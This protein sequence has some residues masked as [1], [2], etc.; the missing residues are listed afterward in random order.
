M[1][2]SVPPRSSA[3]NDVVITGIGIVSSAGVGA[4]EN[5]DAFSR[6]KAPVFDSETFAPHTVHPAP[7]VDWNLQIPKRGDQRQMETWQR[8]GTYCAGLALEDAGIR[9]NEA[10]TTSMDMIVAAAGGERDISVDEMIL[11]A[12]QDRTDFGVLINEKLTTELRPTLFLAQLS[13]LMAGN[14]SI[15]HKVTGSSRTFMGEEGAGMSAVVTAHARLSSGQ[16]THMLV[17]GAFNT[18]HPDM[19]LGYELGHH[20]MHGGWAPVWARESA[21]GGGLIPGSGGAFLVLERH[22]Q[23][24]ARGARIYARLSSVSADSGG[25]EAS[26][27]IARLA[28]LCTANG[29]DTA[30]ALISGASGAKQRTAD[31]KQF[32]SET[33]PNLPLRATTTVT[34]HLREAQFPMAIAIAALSVANRQFPASSDSRNEAETSLRPKSVGV[35][36]VGFEDAEGVA[37]VERME[38]AS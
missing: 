31:E 29:I 16:S 21:D 10:L 3:P 23:A 33:F 1:P 2:Q 15:V 35:I 38:S 13:N 18:E 4:A 26:E 28:A 19:L 9:D 7:E 36:C 25:A 24:V 34:G 32:I 30:S 20:L 22:D 6:G 11:A 12:A 17:G 5:W 14:I 27:T 37:M 8:L